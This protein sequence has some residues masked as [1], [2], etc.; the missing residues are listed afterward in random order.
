[1]TAIKSDVDS[2]SKMSVKIQKPKVVS[3]PNK[4][5]RVT[6]SNAQFEKFRRSAESFQRKYYIN[7]E[8]E[9]KELENFNSKK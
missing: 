4:P 1:M 7:S 3:P 6:N 2:I 9:K 8:Q 5:K